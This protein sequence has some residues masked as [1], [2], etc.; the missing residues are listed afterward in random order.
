MLQN[1]HQSNAVISSLDGVMNS[2]TFLLVRRL[3]TLRRVITILVLF[4]AVSEFGWF[5]E[6][7]QRGFYCDDRTIQRPY[8]GDTI[9]A[10]VIVVSGLLPLLLIW[11]AEALF[12]APSTAEYT[13]MAEVPSSRSSTSWRQTWFWFKKYGRGLLLKLLVVDVL[14]IFAGEHRPHFLDTCRPNVVCEGSEYIAQYT[15]TN[16]E[17]RPYF[18]RDASK[19]FPSGHSSVSVYGAIFM[20][21]YLQCRTPKLRSSMAIPLCQMVLAT[22]AMFCSLSRIID[23]R[24]HWW[25]V[26]AGAAIG[27]VTAF[28]TCTLSCKNFASAKQSTSSIAYKEHGTN[29]IETNGRYK[30]E[31]LR[32]IIHTT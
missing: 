17:E 18:I 22:W 15:C 12:Y 29:L 19:S 6:L 16:T 26:L 11:L 23:N 25:D 5:P 27:A 9:T 31:T 8:N 10:G 1:G 24:H 13:K 30:E 3:V 20:I 2:R 4:I 28:L 21:W 32:N 7:V 14:K